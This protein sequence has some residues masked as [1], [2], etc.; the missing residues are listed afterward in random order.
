MHVVD[1]PHG[2]R[3]TRRVRALLVVVALVVL[4]SAPNQAA[5]HAALV[6]SNPSDGATLS[7]A[8]A[9][10]ELSFDDEITT[11]A[12]VVVT[13]PDGTEAAAGPADVRGGTVTQPV[14]TWPAGGEAGR[15]RIAFRVVSVDGHAVS[16]QLRFT[17]DADS[18]GPAAAT[19]GSGAEADSSAADDQPF[20]RLPT[21]Y[22][23]LGAGAVLIVALLL[24]WP[25]GRRR[26]A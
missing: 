3:P 19:A 5:A 16:D 1:L 12:Y 2:R 14:D 20:G 7:V 25:V 13:A 24:L 26:D 10:V 17:V 9:T 22:L 23:A 4:S 11:P 21:G 8:P 18:S 6:G 15:W